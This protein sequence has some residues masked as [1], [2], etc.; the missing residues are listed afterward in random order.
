MG[1]KAIAMPTGV[2]HA[3]NY[4]DKYFGKSDVK[5]YWGSCR[6]FSRELRARSGL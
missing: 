2:L 1:H 6:D 5:V 4:L 3:L